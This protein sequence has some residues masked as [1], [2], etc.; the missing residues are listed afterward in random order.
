[1]KAIAEAARELV[2]LRD[3]WLNPP[4]VAEADLK[5]RTLTIL[6]N[7]RPAWLDHAHR[8]LDRAVFAAYGWEEEPGVL[9]DQEVLARLLALNHARAAA[10]PVKGAGR[11]KK[12]SG[13][14]VVVEGNADSL[15]E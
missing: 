11:R 7:K 13:A 4:G 10:Q 3:A 2:R 8:V 15:R 5:D 12:A 1:M 6:Y 9:A 14:P